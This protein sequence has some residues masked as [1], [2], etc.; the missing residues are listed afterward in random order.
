MHSAQNEIEEGGAIS[1]QEQH[2]VGSGCAHASCAPGKIVLNLGNLFC[3]CA[4]TLCQQRNKYCFCMPMGK[5]LVK[6][7][8]R[9]CARH[10]CLSQH[11]S[12]SGKICGIFSVCG[13]CS[14][15]SESCN[16]NFVGRVPSR[17]FVAPREHKS[18]SFPYNRCNCFGHK[19]SIED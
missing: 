19:H 1:V 4:C 3:G 14:Q 8:V 13:Q 2:S 9:W 6:G 10:I 12:H 15:N 5:K 16:A 11:Q 7:P 18:Q 17:R